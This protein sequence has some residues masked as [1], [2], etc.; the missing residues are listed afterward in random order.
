MTG[1]ACAIYADYYVRRDNG[2]ILIYRPLI[3]DIYKYS[4]GDVAIYRKLVY[5]KNKA[6]TSVLDWADAYSLRELSKQKDKSVFWS[7]HETQNYEYYRFRK[8][9]NPGFDIFR[10]KK[11]GKIF[12][13]YEPENI[14]SIDQVGI[15]FG[16]YENF[17]INLFD[18]GLANYLYEQ[19]D[20]IIEVNKDILS[21][22]SIKKISEMKEDDNPLFILF[23]L[24][25]V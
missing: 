20:S 14:Y 21:E 1:K 17:F 9:G 4:N 22:E 6:N 12:S 11:N 18:A 15:R 10:N 25:D 16:T 24:K 5:P 8:G 3:D 13:E 19:R 7:Y 2:D 23:S